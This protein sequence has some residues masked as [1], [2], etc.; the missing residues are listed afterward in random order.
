M[1]RQGSTLNAVSWDGNGP[2]GPQKLRPHRNVMPRS[3]PL[4]AFIHCLRTAFSVS[5]DLGSLGPSDDSTRWTMATLSRSFPWRGVVNMKPD[6]MTGWHSKGFRLLPRWKSKLLGIPQLQNDVRHLIRQMAA[7]NVSWGDERIADELTLKLCVRVS[8][9]TVGKYLQRA[10]TECQIL[11]NDG[12]RSSA[13]TPRRAV[14]PTPS[15]G[16]WARTSVP[17]TCLTNSALLLNT[18]CR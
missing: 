9:R 16:I 5:L 2:C 11:S 6:T 10:P 18:R 7:D 1:S 12:R 13:I 4:S 15:T 14:H 8:A 3:P 17:S